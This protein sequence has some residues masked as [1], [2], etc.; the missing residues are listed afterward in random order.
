MAALA[1][2]AS[3]SVLIPLYR[4]RVRRPAGAPALSI[5]RDQLGEVD[6]DLDRGLIGAGEAEAARTEIARR[7]LRADEAGR[8][9]VAAAPERARRIAATVAVIAMPAIALG[10]YLVFGSPQLPD[11][12]LAARLSAPVDEQ[13]IGTLVARVEARLAAAPADGRGWALIA[14]VYLRLG[15]YDDAARALANANRLLGSD[16]VREAD[17]GEALVEVNQGL[18]TADAR[19]AFERARAA[20]PSAVRPRFYLALALSQEGRTAEATAA[21]QELLAGAPPGAPWVEVAR[22]Q[23]AKL[24]AA[25]PPAAGR[26]A[27]PPGPSAADVDAAANMPQADRI[28]M[29]NG[30]VAQLAER[31]RGAPDDPEGWA[32]LVR[33]YMVLGRDQDAKAALADAREKLAA[34]KRAPVDKVAEEFGLK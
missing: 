21:W 11:R 18:V 28:A 34:D 13:D 25:P 1:A 10:L 20:D 2:V 23:L 9:E 30:M 24:D 15:R 4:G 3:L 26:G 19:G 27:P 5:Y 31:L 33:S 14:P 6:R 17:L 16:P 32:R 29:I 12:P 22:G 8:T 7:L